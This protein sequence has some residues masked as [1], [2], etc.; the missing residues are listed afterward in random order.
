MGVMMSKT[1]MTK[2]V[3]IMMVRIH[4]V[5]IMIVRVEIVRI[6][7]VIVEMIMIKMAMIKAVVAVPVFEVP[8]RYSVRVSCDS[9][10][11]IEHML[12]EVVLVREAGVKHEVMVRM[13]SMKFQVPLIMAPPSRVF[14]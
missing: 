13:K 6:M 5:M 10:L 7:M 4:V 9:Y 11:V 8:P 3:M 12:V 14:V 1:V 2:V